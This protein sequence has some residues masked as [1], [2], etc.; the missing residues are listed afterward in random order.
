MDKKIKLAGK[1]VEM[2]NEL[3][4]LILKVQHEAD[5]RPRCGA[6]I[7]LALRHLQDARMRL[8]VALA[9]ENGDDPWTS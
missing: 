9:I 2:R 5:D 4:P 8:G 6:E 7:M 3:S 1:I